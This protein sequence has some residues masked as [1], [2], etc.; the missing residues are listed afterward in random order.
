MIYKQRGFDVIIGNPPY[1]SAIEYS[2]LVSVEEKQFLCNFFKAAKGAWDLYVLFFER[3]I[4]LLKN[5]GTLAFITPNKYLSATYGKGLR[6]L[7]IENINLRNIIDLSRISVFET[8]SVYPIITILSKTPQSKYITVCKPIS[9][10]LLSDN[11]KSVEIESSVMSACPDNVWGVFLSDK[12]NKLSTVLA[13]SVRLDSI[14]QVNATSTAA[15]ADEYGKL[16]KE[17]PSRK[18]GFLKLVNTGTIDPYIS[19]WGQKTLTHQ[20]H[21]FLSPSLPINSKEINDR[22]RSMYL[23]PKIIFAKIGIRAEAFL[24]ETGEYASLNTNCV[25]KP[26]DGFSLKYLV[27]VFNSSVFT[28]IYEL[29]FGS[30]RMSGGYMQ[31]QAPQLRIMPI[32][33]ATL[34]EQSVIASIVSRILSA[35]ASD[36]TANTSA[37]EAQIDAHVFALYGLTDEEIGIVQGV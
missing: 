11:M 19:L 17:L 32:P 6:S 27:G 12:L 1:I 36:P 30:L 10:A 16:I 35:K 31:F 5:E 15:E 26:L 18:K 2:K 14:A 20:H 24:D 13:N 34:A 4:Q 7:F 3:G 23:E 28:T 33:K 25:Y 37:L 9:S 8:A 29:L 22:R 21:R